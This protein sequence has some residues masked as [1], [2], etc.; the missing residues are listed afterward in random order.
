MMSIAAALIGCD[1]D[2]P[3]RAYQA[4]KD[5][6]RS[7]LAMAGPEQ[8]TTPVSASPAP[9]E[10]RGSVEWQVP[11]GWRQLPGGQMRHASFQVLPDDPNLQLSVIPLGPENTLL[12][13]VIR[14]QGQLGL[15]PTNESELPKLAQTVKI[16]SG[17]DAQVVDLVGPSAPDKSAQR[18]LAALVPHDGKVWFFKL[19]GPSHK[20]ESQKQNFDA[21]LRSVRFTNGGTTG[22]VGPPASAGA[23]SSASSGTGAPATGPAGLS[24]SIPSDWTAQADRPMRLATFTAG[25]DAPQAEVVVTRFP[26]NSGS[27]L[28]NINCWRGQAGVEPIT[29]ATQQPRESINVDGHDGAVYDFAS[30]QKRIRVAM[31]PVGDQAYFFKL[32]GT[33]DGV[34]K[35]KD[36]F[37]QFVASVKFGG[38]R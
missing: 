34:A 33:A 1:G 13:N 21:F 31:I 12:P 36:E 19:Q 29:D 4:P 3:V 26:A 37:D 15:P 20:I 24:W 14:W 5:S 16:A 22:P 17:E 2:E 27:L 6:S 30:A 8:P 32:Q 35:Q 38:T 23:S 7:T 18:I 10:P 9:A 28:D 25:P 11:A